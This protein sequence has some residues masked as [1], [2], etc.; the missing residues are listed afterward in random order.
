MARKGDFEKAEELAQTLKRDIEAYDESKMGTYWFAAGVI[1]FEKGDYEAAVA[2]FEKS[3]EKSLRYDTVFRWR[4]MLGRAYLELG[5]LGDAVAT[6]EKA[7]SR[8]DDS[9]LYAPIDAVRAHYFLGLAYE[10]SGWNNKAI[11]QYEEF[12][13]IWKDADPGISEIEDARQRLARLKGGA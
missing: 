7:L 12:L 6:F 8:Y 4:F 11:E 1:D 10:Q 13:D 2:A 9:R 5:R 3:L